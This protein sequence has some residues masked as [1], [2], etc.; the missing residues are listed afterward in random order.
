MN[1]KVEALELDFP[2]ERRVLAYPNTPA[3]RRIDTSEAAAAA[4]R[5]HA[6][7]VRDLVINALR[8]KPMTV[9]EC[10]AALKMPI[11]TVQPRFSELRKLRLIEDTGQRRVNAA[12]GKSAAVWGA[13]LEDG[14]SV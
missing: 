11:P 12:S 5:K 4:M 6:Q 10:A 1:Q 14:G 2:N 3:A 7:T 13:T 8:R 9:H